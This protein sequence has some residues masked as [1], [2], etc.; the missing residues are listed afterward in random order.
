VRAVVVSSPLHSRGEGDHE[1]VE[2]SVAE[3]RRCV[4]ATP[5]RLA[6]ARHLPIAVAMG[7][8]TGS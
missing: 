2:G 7:E 4:G 8:E 1:V 3:R 6:K 5:L